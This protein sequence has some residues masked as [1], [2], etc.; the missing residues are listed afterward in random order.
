MRIDCAQSGEE[1]V[2]AIRAEKAR[3]NAVFM[4]HMMPGMDGIEATRIIREEIGTEYARTVPIIA[5]T[6]NAIVGAE[7]MFL[8]KGFQAFISKPIEMAL[9]DAVIREWVRDKSKEA[10]RTGDPTLPN[11]RNLGN[12]HVVSSRRNEIDW[13]TFGKEIAGLDIDKGLER[14]N[15]D[16]EAFWAVLHSFASNT[17]PILNTIKEVTPKTLADYAIIVHGIKGACFCICASTVG[18]KAGALEK[19]AKAGDFAF[20]RD[21]HPIFL[22][23]AFKL[24]DDLDE[25]LRKIDKRNSPFQ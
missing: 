24:L 16:K 13:W 5:L 11:Q 6:A 7:K 3:Y 19:A 4:D 12:R 8:S 9:L 20:V 18:G 25:M 1:A 21:N 22:T 15:G 2:D 17:R 10:P 23:D 14:M